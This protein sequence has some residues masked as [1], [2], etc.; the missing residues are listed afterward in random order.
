MKLKRLSLPYI[1]WMVVFT[2][3]PI[4]SG[5]IIPKTRQTPV[6]IGPKIF[7]GHPKTD[8]DFF[9]MPVF[10][11]WDASVRRSRPD[12]GLHRRQEITLGHAAIWI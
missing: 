10:R 5:K 11:P 2:L 3:I 6:N 7:S 8:G 9:L 12:I 1:F 4:F